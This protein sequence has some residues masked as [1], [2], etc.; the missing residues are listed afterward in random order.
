MN[1][2]R[3]VRR[4]SQVELDECVGRVTQERDKYLRANEWLVAENL[5]L[6]L[7]ND[8]LKA[9]LADADAYLLEIDTNARRLGSAVREY[10]GHPSAHNVGESIQPASPVRTPV[11]TARSQ[12]WLSVVKSDASPTTS[13]E[14][15]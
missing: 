11:S 12:R 9:Q 13:K 5:S 7:E 10:V 1:A 2:S 14:D 4:Y 8:G 3:R 6:R 15:A